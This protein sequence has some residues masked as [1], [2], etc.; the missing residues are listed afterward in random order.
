MSHQRGIGEVDTTPVLLLVAVG[1]GVVTVPLAGG[2]LSALT[3]VKLRLVPVI[4][5]ALAIQIGITALASDGSPWVHRG[6]HL[7]SY[8]LAA[9]FFVA[10]RH[11]VGLWIVALG[12][13]LN[14]VAI[15]ANN[16]LM[17]AAPDAL[18]SAGLVSKADGFRNSTALPHPRLLVFGDIFAVPKGWPLANVFSI[19]D[20]IIAVGVLV[21]IHALCGSRLSYESHR[22]F[23]NDRSV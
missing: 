19:G 12:A 22:P 1:L 14:L 10:N 7:A 6:L 15:V 2:R 17:P 21:T 4:F 11:I 9:A 13:S 23:I 5:V 20:V 3:D 18:R 16:G 8:G